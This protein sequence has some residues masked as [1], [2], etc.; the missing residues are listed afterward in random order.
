MGID[1]TNITLVLERSAFSNDE[2]GSRGVSEID[3]SA[4]SVGAFAREGEFTVCEG[5][6]PLIGELADRE[7]TGA[8]REGASVRVLNN[9]EGRGFNSILRGVVRQSKG[10]CILFRFFCAANGNVAEG[11]DGELLV[12]GIFVRNRKSARLSSTDGGS[13]SLQGTLDG[14]GFIFREP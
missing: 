9:R 13:S 5:H 3:R 6:R 4:G 12:A 8:E 10:T 7:L 14:S 1:C 11:D 2:G